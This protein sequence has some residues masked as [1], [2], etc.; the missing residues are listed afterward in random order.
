MNFIYI[1]VVCFLVIFLIVYTI[2]SKMNKELLRITKIEE[3][4]NKA[5]TAQLNKLEIDNIKHKININK[6]ITYFNTL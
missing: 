2:I 3:E 4:N 6:F 5:V 1:A